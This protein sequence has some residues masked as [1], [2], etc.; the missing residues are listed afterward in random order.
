MQFY[1]RKLSLVA[2]K[3]QKQCKFSNRF[4]KTIFKFT[5]KSYTTEI[6]KNRRM[7]NEN[8]ITDI[9]CIQIYIIYNVFKLFVVQCK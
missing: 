8:T 5:I 2:K 1:Q 3:L 7:L 9:V 6:F 4:Y